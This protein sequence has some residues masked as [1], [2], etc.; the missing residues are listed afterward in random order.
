MSKSKSPLSK[1]SKTR[2]VKGRQSKK[3]EDKLAKRGRKSKR[4]LDEVD[5]SILQR[6]RDL[7]RIF[8][9]LKKEAT[10]QKRRPFS[11][12]SKEFASCV[13]VIENIRDLEQHFNTEVNLN[14]FVRAH[15]ELHGEGT[16]ITHLLGQFSYTNYVNYQ[17]AKYAEVVQ[18][19]REEQVQYELELLRETSRVY[20]LE[21]EA[22]FDVLYPSGLLAYLL[23]ALGEEKEGG[24]I[25]GHQEAAVL[26]KLP[27][28]DD[29]AAIR[30]LRVHVSGWNC[31]GG[32]LRRS[33]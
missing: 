31:E 10:G 11:E 28:E 6:A 27:A 20:D 7:N 24:N 16:F 2:S 4:K 21:L 23:E 8:A 13:R 33:D 18:M 19:T 29:Q 3:I 5:S 12:A 1:L 32:V 14:D 26:S 15:F 17:Q 25:E 9:T 30:R 22:A